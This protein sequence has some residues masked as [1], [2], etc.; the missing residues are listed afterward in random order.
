MQF[1]WYYSQSQKEDMSKSVK[2]HGFENGAD[3]VDDIAVVFKGKKDA[4]PLPLLMFNLPER[5][6]ERQHACYQ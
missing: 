6:V 1:F 4:D 2:A 5:Q 3:S